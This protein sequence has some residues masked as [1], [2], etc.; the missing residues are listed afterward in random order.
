MGIVDG[1]FGNWNGKSLDTDGFPQNQRF[2]CYDV[3]IQYGNDVVGHGYISAHPAGGARDLFENFD[4]LGLGKWYKRIAND[5]SD[6]NQVPQKGDVVIWNG[7]DPR[8]HV[9][10]FDHLV[11]ANSFVS[12]D[13]NWGGTYCHYV[14]H[15][16][17]HVIGWLRPLKFIPQAV[18]APTPAAASTSTGGNKLMTPEFIIKTYEAVQGRTPTQGEI[19]FHMAKSNPTSF[20]NGFGGTERWRALQSQIDQLVATNSSLSVQLSQA[21]EQLTA[22]AKERDSLRSEVDKMISTAPEKTA[23]ATT[24]VRYVRLEKDIKVAATKDPTNVYGISDVT[25]TVNGQVAKGF[26]FTAVGKAI[27]SNGSTYY[28]SAGSFGDADTTGTA[29]VAQGIVS[30]DLELVK[31]APRATIDPANP[32]SWKATFKVNKAGSYIATDSATITDL[33][34]KLE[35]VHIDKGTT[36]NVAGEFEKEGQHFY[37]TRT[38]VQNGSWYGIPV[39]VMETSEEDFDIGELQAMQAALEGLA[40][41]DKLTIRERAAIAI[42]RRDGALSGII[43]AVVKSI[44]RKG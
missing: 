8:G 34:G 25:P 3:F 21:T 18:T 6:P 28:M 42:G 14:T 27:H 23:E 39:E 13:Q 33:D 37:R 26:S 11:N 38:S 19:D 1:F 15:N 29:K 12:F 10:I 17:Q 5:P 9:A 22:I 41:A 43:S 2:Q 24:I 20:I 16:W 31:E 4:G 36:V 30:S 32:D 35:A 40:E 44:K 7:P